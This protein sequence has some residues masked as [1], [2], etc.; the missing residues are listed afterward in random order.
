MKRLFRGTAAALLAAGGVGSVG[1]VTTDRIPQTVCTD[2]GNG[3]TG[4]HW[5]WDPHWPERYNYTARQEVLAPFAQQVTNGQVL[6][7]TI[8]NWHF[9]AGSDKLNSAG[10]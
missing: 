9:E 4:T 7:Q 8:W 6:N 1:C 10:L 5:P 2:T 3:A